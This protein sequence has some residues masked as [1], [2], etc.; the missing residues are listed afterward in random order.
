[1][2][3]L[4]ILML[5]IGIGTGIWVFFDKKGETPNTDN[6]ATADSVFTPSQPVVAPTTPAIVPTEPTETTE[7]EVT[8]EAGEGVETEEP[9]IGPTVTP[10]SL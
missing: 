3:V 5:L 1:M 6:Q 9:A 7:T 2:G 4:A 10:G 8:G